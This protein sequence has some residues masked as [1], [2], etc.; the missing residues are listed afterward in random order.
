MARL[1]RL[2][3][4]G[5]MAAGVGHE[6]R[7]PMTTVRGYLQLL[8]QRPEFV[9]YARHFNLMIEELDRM[10][11]IITEFLSLGSAKEAP[12]NRRRAG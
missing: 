11:G 6:V 8:K 7:N 5:E 2:N 9:A 12:P 3:T 1:D 4:L 10:N